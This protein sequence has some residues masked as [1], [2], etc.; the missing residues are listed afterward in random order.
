VVRSSRALLA[1][2]GAVRSTCEQLRHKRDERIN[3]CWFVVHGGTKMHAPTVREMSG[4]KS[5]S[6]YKNWRKSV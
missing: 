1:Y 2:V 5:R 6:R 3:R 4:Y